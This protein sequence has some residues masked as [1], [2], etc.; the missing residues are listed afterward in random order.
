V[1]AAKE[2]YSCQLEGFDYC[3][4]HS[5]NEQRWVRAQVMYF[6]SNQAE[7]AHEEGNAGGANMFVYSLRRCE[8]KT[9]GCTE[10]WCRRFRPRVLAEA[11][12]GATTVLV[13][14][15]KPNWVCF[16]NRYQTTNA[17]RGYLRFFGC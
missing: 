15:A 14:D 13:D 5:K 6:L 3:D 17:E 1:T 8:A 11:Q 2:K 16:D 10:L 12:S 4:W 7:Q 9:G